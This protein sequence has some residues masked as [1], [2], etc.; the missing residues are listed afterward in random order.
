MR[1]GSSWNRCRLF[2]LVIG[3]VWIISLSSCSRI[4]LLRYPQK[5]AEVHASESLTQIMLVNPTPKI[6]LRV[7]ESYRDGLPAS[8]SR[9]QP[10]SRS[11]VAYEPSF[12]TGSD[13]YAEKLLYNAIEKQLF[14][15]GFTVRDRRLFND[16]LDKAGSVDYSKVHGLT[17]TDLILEWINLDRQVNYDTNVCYRV[18]RKGR[19]KSI[20]L[21][22]PFQ[23]QGASIEFKLIAVKTNE[24]VGTYKIHYTPCTEGCIYRYKNGQLIPVTTRTNVKSYDVMNQ[25]ELEVF[26]ADA[27]KQ[28][29]QA[30]H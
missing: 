21:L 5:P 26:L 9:S 23:R 25:N 15:E 3:L 29:V 27:T 30:M 2:C 1:D 7:P 19:E 24:V 18:L 8:S 13:M 28:I 12:G 17:N 10:G 16:V 20:E 22:E 14:Q 4:V 6:V 11:R